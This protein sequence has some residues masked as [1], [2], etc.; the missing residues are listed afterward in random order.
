MP[1]AASSSVIESGSS[2]TPVAIAESPSATDRNSG[3]AKNRPAWQQVLEEER[4]ESAAQRAV[5]EDR[6][7]DERLRRRERA[8]GSPRRRTATA[9]RRRRG[10]AR[11]TGERP[12]HSGASG[13]GWT[14]P[15]EPALR[16][17]NTISARPS[18]DSAVPTRSSRGRVSGGASAIRRADGEDRDHDQDLADEHPAPRRVG[19]EQPADQRTGGD[20]DRP[21]RGD[22]PVGTRAPGR[23]EVRRHQRDDR[24]QD[25]RGAD[26]LE[27]RPAEHQHGRGSARSR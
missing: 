3:T 25:Q 12:S 26:A 16:I 15:H 4:G 7:V 14:N 10:S 27:E 1:T 23:L 6:R 5:P 18:A 22:Q 11:S 21:G 17:A 8:A 9:R 20:G 24:R 2:R 19:R 13:L